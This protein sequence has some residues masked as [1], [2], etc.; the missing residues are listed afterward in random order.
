MR[1]GQTREYKISPPEGIQAIDA[2]S[3]RTASLYETIRDDIISGKIKVDPVFDA[4]AVR[5]LM[6]DVSAPAP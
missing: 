4:Q 3:E 5:A 6:N 2:S 1:L